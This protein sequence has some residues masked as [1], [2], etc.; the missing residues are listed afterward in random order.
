MMNPS[1]AT[2]REYLLKTIDAEIKS[3][4]GSLQALRYRSNEP[5]P[6]S[7]LPTEVIEPI[8]SLLRVP[9]TSSP[10]KLGGKPG[11]PH[12]Y[13]WEGGQIALFVDG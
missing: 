7:S 10:S 11:H 13:G 12:E 9:G 4:E 3:L 5:A 1:E 6:I 2:P 8:F